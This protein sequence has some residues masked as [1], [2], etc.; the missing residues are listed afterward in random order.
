MADDLLPSRSL[1]KS[2]DKKRA[3]NWEKSV[4]SSRCDGALSSRR[5]SP[6]CFGDPDIRCDEGHGECQKQESRPEIGNVGDK[7][8]RCRANKNARVAER[9]DR[10]NSQARRHGAGA[11]R[12][13]RTGTMFEAP[14][15][16]RTNPKI[17]ISGEGTETTTR[18]PAA[19]TQPPSNRIHLSSLARIRGFVV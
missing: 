2:D 13:R 15:P 1:E 12:N 11:T 6:L 5:A 14:S 18:N 8:D 9:R 7:P 16:T 10:G 4:R 19:A 3:G 17:S